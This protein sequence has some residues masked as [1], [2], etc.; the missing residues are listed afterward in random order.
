MCNELTPV[1]RWMILAASAALVI[2]LYVGAMAQRQ[3]HRGGFEFKDVYADVAKSAPARTYEQG[4]ADG[5][6]E[7]QTFNPFECP[8]GVAILKMIDQCNDA[9]DADSPAAC[10]RLQLVDQSC[11]R[12]RALEAMSYETR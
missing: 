6:H 10:K 9:T 11:R 12:R 5:L 4:Y 7:G 1:N 8:K 3:A 2:G